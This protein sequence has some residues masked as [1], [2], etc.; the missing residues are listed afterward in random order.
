MRVAYV[1]PELLSADHDVADFDCG[2]APL[3]DWLQRR[4]L[5]NQ[6]SWTTR[7]WVVT[8]AGS[9]EV[10]AFYASCTGSVLRSTTTRTIRQGQPE[11]V[12]ALLL[13][14]MGVDRHHQG[15]GVGAALLKHF[16]A[17]ALEVSASVGVRLLLV[18]AKDDAAKV[19]YQRYGFVASPVDPLTMMLLLP[20][21][22]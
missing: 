15:R 21:G 1:G 4:A 5:D 18:H 20:A 19:F 12:P 8:E 6:H 7:T 14:R 2:R 9:P 22:V 3:N 16:V 13:A 10:I 11:Q 17:K